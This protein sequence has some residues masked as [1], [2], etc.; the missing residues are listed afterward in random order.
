MRA[1]VLCGGRGTRAYP[2]TAELPKPL[3]EIGGRPILRHVLDI[4]ARQRVTEFVLAA[5][6][7]ADAITAFAESLPSHWRVD[8]VDTG[9]EAGTAERVRACLDHLGEAFHA[10]YGDG[11][12]NVDL[13]RLAAR[14]REH[15]GTGTVTAVPLPSPYGTLDLGPGDA[16]CGFREK[17]RL[18]EHWI[19]AGFF[20]FDRSALA[21]PG[22]DLER[23]V[24]P[25]LA[26]SGELFV[27]RHEGF[28]ASL[29]TYKDQMDLDA[30]ATSGDPPWQG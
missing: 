9:V 11:V 1:L 12:G 17:P 30:L 3:L 26:G 20:V 14:H 25:A 27:Y 28:W 8:V 24:L 21:H 16:V 19:N 5:G 6:F 7:H 23:D 18:P 4:Y 13:D 29:D 2:L 15:P 22:D 10:T